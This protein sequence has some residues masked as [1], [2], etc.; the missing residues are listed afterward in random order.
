MII[1]GLEHGMG[2]N[3]IS[4]TTQRAWPRGLTANSLHRK[5]TCTTSSGEQLRLWFIGATAA[6]ISV[7]SP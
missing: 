3:R 5:L 7:T 6:H 1:F 2:F 4:F